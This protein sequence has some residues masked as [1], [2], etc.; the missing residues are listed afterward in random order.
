MCEKMSGRREKFSNGVK[1]ERQII[2]TG[3]G[4]KGK[5]SCEMSVRVHKE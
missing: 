2:Q 4:G 3:I 5:E 1:V